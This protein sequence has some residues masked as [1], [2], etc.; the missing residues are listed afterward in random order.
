MSDE[1]AKQPDTDREQARNAPAGSP[2]Q[3]AEPSGS[4]GDSPATAG[5]GPTAVVSNTPE[6]RD[7]QL[8][9]SAPG[10]V[11]TTPGSAGDK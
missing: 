2:K 7:G 8:N 5:P 4:K 1:Q 10:D 9:P 11:G 3:G 6:N